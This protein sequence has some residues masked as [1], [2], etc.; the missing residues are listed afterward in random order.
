[1]PTKKPTNTKKNTQETLHQTIKKLEEDITRL[2]ADV[3]DKND[4]YLRTLADYQN[5]QKRRDKELL[6]R[7]DELKKKYLTELLDFQ[8]LLKKAYED[9]NPK[10]GL[11]LLIG[12]LDKFLEK[13][14]VRY[15]ECKGKPFDYTHQHAISTIEKEDCAEGTV[16]DE[17]KKGYMMGD[18]LLRPCQVIVTKK[19]ETQK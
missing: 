13:E 18:K 17:V 16:L 7:E 8:E 15:I 10:E 12:N 5:Y 1:M 6:C 2:Q 4:K 11:K 9:N 3:N 14:G 19:K